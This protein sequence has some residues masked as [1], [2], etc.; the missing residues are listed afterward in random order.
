MAEPQEPSQNP[1]KITINTGNSSTPSQMRMVRQ[2]IDIYGGPLPPAEMMKALKE[3]DPLIVDAIM[4]RFEEDSKFQRDQEARDNQH[5]RDMEA[6]DRLA[7]ENATNAMIQNEF[8]L[9]RKGQ[10]YAFGSVALFMIVAIAFTLTGHENIA[11][12]FAAGDGAF[13]VSLVI[14]FLKGKLP[15]PAS[16]QKLDDEEEIE[17]TAENS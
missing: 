13:L 8:R 3:V 9:G 1:N 6:A 14:A 16:Q 7:G 2:E 15:K 12:A 17:P 5:R 10:D 11:I 4:K